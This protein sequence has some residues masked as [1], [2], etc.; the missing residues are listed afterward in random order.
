MFASCHPCVRFA[1]SFIASTSLAATL[2]MLPL[3]DAA[4]EGAHSLSAQ[5]SEVIK[6]GLDLPARTLLPA[7][8][9]NWEGGRIAFT[10]KVDPEKPN[11]L[12]VRLWGGDVNHNLLLLF[13]EGKQIGYRHLGDIDLLDLGSDEPAYNG[14]F[15]YNTTP[16]P[17][18]LTKGKKQLAFE[19]RSNGRIWGYG[20]NFEQYQKPMTEP[21]RG[22]Y[23]LYTHTDGCFVPPVG[24]KQ[25]DAP[26]NAL[27]RKEP[28]P[29]VIEQVKARV[30]RELA[31]T[32]K[33]RRPPGQVSM[34]LLARAYSVKWTPAFE[35]PKVVEKIVQGGDELFARFRKDPK[36]A[37]ADPGV[38]NADWF[39]LGLAGD[40]IR[41]VAKPLAPL[42]DAQI[43]DGRGGK[44][45]RRAAWSEMLVASREW[46]R[47]N[48]RQYTNQAMIKDMN[49]YRANRGIA[50]IDP[51]RAMPEKDALRYLYEAIGLQ[52]W[53]GD[54]LEGGGSAKPLGDAYL[55]LTAKGLT[56]ELG[57]VG[58][59]GEVLDWVTQIYDATREP[60]QPGDPKIKAQLERIA[61]ARG[62]FRYPMLD[63]EGNRAMRIETAVGWRD[64]HLPGDVTYGERQTWDASTLYTAAATLDAASIGYAQ[65]MFAD[66]QFFESV[67]DQLKGGGTRI[68]AGLLGVPEQYEL[69]AA[70][71]P[72]SRRLPMS[73]AVDF[74]WADEEN[75][76]LA[77]KRGDEILYASLYWRARHAVNNLARIH[78]LTPRFARVAVVREETQFEPGGMTWKRPDWINFGFA[79]GGLRYPNAPKSAHAGEVLPIAKIPAGID[80]KPGKENIHAGKAQFYTLRYGPYLIGMN[81]TLDKTFELRA[82]EGVREAPELVTGKTVPLP[83]PLRVGPR[84]TR[85]LY[86]RE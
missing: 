71:P 81:T 36:I 47:R 5:R 6:G 10:M 16:L 30:S 23:A 8:A 15:F 72:S 82:P 45:T 76:V 41:L 18:E 44:I 86:I 24:E 34:H 58:L 62:V 55:Q 4:A 74:A 21:T 19:V 31:G 53:L 29:E 46:H 32:L 69:L 84:S 14:R 37:Q 75:G 27:V 65:Q 73:M 28:G 85:I 50:A 3:G 57:Y 54:D 60:G 78:H 61:D 33:D 79:N 59:Y 83:S 26:V 39:G 2:D 51:A 12:T 35:N 38:Y 11:Y 20:T 56:K 1:L 70:Q 63:A 13:A 67:R 66:N 43:D 42:L 25:G 22:I 48:R 77:I 68:T 17:L 40:A 49:I 64:T 52:P 7:E 9:A 80:F